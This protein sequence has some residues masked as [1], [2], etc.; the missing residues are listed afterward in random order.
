[1]KDNTSRPSGGDHD[2]NVLDFADYPEVVTDGVAGVSIIGREAWIMFR[3][4]T[5]FHK[6]D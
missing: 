1:M 5:R 2:K 3:R 4:S 6:P